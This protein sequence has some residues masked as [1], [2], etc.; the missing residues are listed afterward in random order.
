[1]CFSLQVSIYAF[2]FILACLALIYVRQRSGYD[3]IK[4]RWAALVILSA[5]FIQLMDAIFWL[6][7]VQQGKDVVTCAGYTVAECTCAH[8]RTQEISCFL[9]NSTTNLNRVTTIITS[10]ILAFQP[11]IAL[12]AAFM[13]G[14]IPRVHKLIIWIPYLL[15][16]IAVIVGTA[17]SW[18]YTRLSESGKIIW[19]GGNI[20][21]ESAIV[22]TALLVFPF[23]YA[24]NSFS[25]VI[26]MLTVVAASFASYVFTDAFGSMWCFFT[27][28]FA[29]AVLIDPFFPKKKKSSSYI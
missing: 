28:I 22:H 18:D 4:D 23:V 1:M 29:F 16:F 10:I 11:P 27:V 17:I 8:S 19:G 24:K 13:W 7:I 25:K 15:Y 12:L 20:G 3:G 21:V 26:W 6:D 2:T 5:V 9:Y 14:R